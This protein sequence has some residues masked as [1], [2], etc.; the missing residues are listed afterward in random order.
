MEKKDNKCIR[1][2]LEG[3][4]I[5][6]A[7]FGKELIHLLDALFV[8]TEAYNAE[9]IGIDA[10]ESNCIT[11]K[12]LVPLAFSFAA[13]SS[14][15]LNNPNATLIQVSQSAKSVNKI[16]AKHRAQLYCFDNGIEVARYDGCNQ[17]IPFRDIQLGKSTTSIYGELVNVGGSETINIHIK[18]PIQSRMIKLNVSKDF[19]RQLAPK[20]YTTVGVFAEVEIMNNEIVGGR[21]LNIVDYTPK[22]L[23]E[24][25]RNDAIPSFGKEY[26]GVNIEEFLNNLRGGIE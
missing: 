26:S 23:D 24:W 7:S 9:P 18:S 14:V 4:G 12:F 17:K 5:T 10:V 6:P 15:Q 11:V 21:V 22:P 19:A 25:L 20:I 8:L 3:D 2:K 13:F 16:L 1:F